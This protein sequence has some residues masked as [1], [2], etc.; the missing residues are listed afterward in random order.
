MGTSKAITKLLIVTALTILSGASYAN[1][2][3]SIIISKSESERRV[4]FASLLKNS[5]ESCGSAITTFFQGFTK[6]NEAIW[7]VKCSNGRAY[8]ILIKDN[9]TGSTTILDC[10][11]LKVIGAGECFKKF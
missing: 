2:A 10:G 1:K 5:N 4:V 7:N 6:E 8:A 9:E 11:V 3:H